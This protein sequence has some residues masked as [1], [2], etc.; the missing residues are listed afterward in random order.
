MLIDQ[1]THFPRSPAALIDYLKNYPLLKVKFSKSNKEDKYIYQGY[2]ITDENIKATFSTS[3]GT[4]ITFPIAC[5]ADIQFNTDGFV[6]T[7][8]KTDTATYLYVG[9]K[10]WQTDISPEQL[11]IFEWDRVFEEFERIKRI[12]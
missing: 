4:L 6:A 10:P 11:A 1:W 7:L 12:K 5:T 3:S 2:D 9:P 8:N